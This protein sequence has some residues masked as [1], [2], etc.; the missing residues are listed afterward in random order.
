MNRLVRI[1]FLKLRTTPALWITIAL[2]VLLSALPAAV[3]VIFAGQGQNP[4]PGNVETIASVFAVGSFTSIAMLVMGILLTAG[5]D[6]HRTNLATFLGEPRRERVLAAKLVTAGVLGA[7][8][9]ALA[10]G[11]A[12][13]VGIPLLASRGVHDLHVDV[14]ALGLGTVTISACYGLLGV[15][16]GAL[17]RNTVG[18]ILGGLAWV[19]VIELA[20]LQPAAPSLAKWLPTGAGVALTRAGEQSSH[21]LPPAVAAVVLVCWAVGICMVASAVSLRREVR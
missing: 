19:V 20:I 10:F 8:V 1:E 18:A 4:P 14:L 21:L 11:L 7:A 5:E 13:A 9:G 6:R 16:L 2:S 17:T 12:A 15:A 3:T